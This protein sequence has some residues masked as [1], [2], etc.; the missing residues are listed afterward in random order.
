[1]IYALYHSPGETV[2]IIGDVLKEFKLPFKE[3]H[4]HDG[5]GLPRETGDLDGLIV[6]GGPMNVDETLQFPFLLPEVQLI[7]RTISD[8]KPVLGICLG[9]QLMAKALGEKIFKNDKKEVGWHPIHMAPAA[10]NDP[11]FKNFPPTL[12]VLHW[13]GDTFNIPKG[14]AHLARSPHCNSQAFRWGKHAYALQFHF[15][16]TPPMLKGWCNAKSEQ[17]FIQ[18]AGEEPKQIVNA[19]PQAYAAL[20]PAAKQF[21]SSY[22]KLAYPHVLAAV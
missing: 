1:M 14:A 16:V 21:F 9:A 20:E 18:A 11:L 17:E 15:E 13:H 4:L 22:L 6:M 2:G 8:G 5:E 19:T 12:E 3:V 7:E 10:K